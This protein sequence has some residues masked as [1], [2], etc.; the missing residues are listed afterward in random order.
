MTV[1]AI[2]PTGVKNPKLLNET[3]IVNNWALVEDA[4]EADR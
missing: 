1:V 3:G 2:I 4:K